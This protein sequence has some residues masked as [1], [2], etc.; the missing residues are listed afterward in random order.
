MASV[1]TTA[2]S[3]DNDYYKVTSNGGLNECYQYD[4][5][6]GYYSGYAL[7]NCVGYVWG[8]WYEML[9]SRPNGL[10]R[11]N[12]ET[13]YP[14]ITGYKKGQT[15]HVGD[16]ACW[17][18]NTGNAFTDNTNGGHVAI[19]I[20][21]GDDYIKVA[22]SNYVRYD[23]HP[24]DYMNYWWEIQKYYKRNGGYYVG[25]YLAF[26][27]F[28]YYPDNVDP[29]PTPD[30]DP[31]PDTDKCTVTL[32]VS[33]DGAGSVTGAGTYEIGETATI[34]AI[35]NKGY[36]F[37]KWSD[38][39]TSALRYWKM[40][41]KQQV[42]LT[43][44]F[45]KKDKLKGTLQ[46]TYIIKALNVLYGT[47][48]NGTKRKKALGKDYTQVQ[49]IVNK[50]ILKYSIYDRIAMQVWLGLY[51]NGAVRKLRLTKLGYNYV[52]VQSHVKKFNKTKKVLE[53]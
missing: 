46:D 29:T 2:P 26:Q 35:A 24:N 11:T 6:R 1:R 10:V 52:T 5:Y 50:L 23:Q 48:G 32:Y 42:V 4:T 41:Y 18:D 33:P 40:D 22:Q 53:Y 44:Y 16:I 39:Y 15:A 8:A 45:K 3:K 31:T 13:F 43:A 17:K 47:Y 9:G 7:P 30:P 51:G 25:N 12:A 37:E 21:V 20:E 34:E 28:I 19:V 14:N 27:G 36:E 38:G 49:L